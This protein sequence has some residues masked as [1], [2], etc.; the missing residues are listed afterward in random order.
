MPIYEYAC[1]RCDRT[2]EELVR[3][4]QDA[5]RVACPHCGGRKV[6]RRP[7]VFAAHAAASRPTTPPAG[8]G[9]CGLGDGACPLAGR[10]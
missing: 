2:F 3:S 4:E 1:A 5:N 9:Q 10:G 7:S 6:T 8:C